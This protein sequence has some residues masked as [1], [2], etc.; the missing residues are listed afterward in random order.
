VTE[1][2]VV[3]GIGVIS[4]LN[5]EGDTERFWTAIRVGEEGV[6]PVRSF[7]ASSYPCKVAAEIPRDMLG[8]G[9]GGGAVMQMARIAF[10]R[11]IA[12]ADLTGKVDPKRT[13]LVLGTVLG[14]VVSGD[15]YLRGGALQ[16]EEMKSLLRR[17][18]M[19]AIAASLASSARIG[20][21]VLTV[22]TACASGTD[23]IGIAFRKIRNGD[24]DAVVAGGVDAV[25]EFSFSGFSAL[26][27]LT[28]SKV[29]PFSR[30]RSGIALGEGAAFL[31]LEREN[32]AIARGACILGRI[33]GY[34][35]ALDATH[36]TA[37]HRDG[38]GLSSA[39]TS[40]IR[41]TGVEPDRIDYVNAHGTG[42]LY[43]DWMETR[44]LRASLG[45]HAGAV[46]VSS[47]KAVLGHAFGAA[48]AMEAAVCLLAIRDG[49]VPP[50]ANFEEADPGCDI[51]C[52]PNRERSVPVRVALSVSAGFGGQ[53]GALVLAAR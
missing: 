18:P 24:L 11:A 5:P 32:N 45:P 22:S 25:S 35:S 52:V 15:R 17:Y 6:L 39:I 48:G 10:R 34:G 38:R 51:D 19:R 33:A 8:A 27:A 20:G 37:P 16:D 40:A 50:T 4:P 3:T 46:P 43:N 53:N 28:L 21:P 41:E 14:G 42:T 1:P 36:L 13:G 2:V 47:I 44:A 29:R 49:V 30:N 7:D 12:D 9:G 23:A 31:V 26:N